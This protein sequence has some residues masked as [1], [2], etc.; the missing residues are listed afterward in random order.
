VDLGSSYQG[1]LF[2]IGTHCGLDPQATKK[3]QNAT[4]IWKGI[5]SAFQLIGNRFFWKNGSGE[6]VLV[7]LYHWIGCKQAYKLPFHLICELQRKSYYTLQ[8]IT[9][10]N[11]NIGKQRWLSWREINVIEESVASWENYIKIV[12]ISFV[13]LTEQYNQLV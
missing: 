7:G 11:Q 4:I 3:L 8:K 1:K 13:T 6:Q 9:H 2:P 12:Q 10:C 5:M